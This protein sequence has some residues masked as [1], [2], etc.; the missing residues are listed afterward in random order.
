MVDD[1]NGSGFTGSARGRKASTRSHTT[2]R[3]DPARA[4]N[5]SVRMETCTLTAVGT[6][7]EETGFTFPIVV[8]NNST[9]EQFRATIFAKYPWGLCDAVELRYWD[10]SKVDWVPVQS[11]NELENAEEPTLQVAAVEEDDGTDAEDS[12]QE[13]PQASVLSPRKNYKKEIV[14]GAS[15][16]KKQ[17]TTIEVPGVL[18]P[19]PTKNTRSK[20]RLAPIQLRT[21]RAKN[22]SFSCSFAL[23][24]DY[25]R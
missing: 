19:N 4:F 23:A 10:V 9:F 8:D 22:S 2:L 12:P 20:S 18:V 24:G 15:P 21:P 13:P 11:D 5:I 1:D 17:T 6:E 16:A 7:G 25:L 3:T 14:R